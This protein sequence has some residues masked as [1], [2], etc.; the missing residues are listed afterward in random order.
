MAKVSN[1]TTRALLGLLVG[2]ASVCS[3]GG[4][5]EPIR[6]DTAQWAW[7]GAPAII[8][9]PGA[10]A[11]INAFS[12][13][14][15]V[16]NRH[17]APQ[18]GLS[19]ALDFQPNGD[20]IE[21]DA[22]TAVAFSH[23]GQYVIVAAAGKSP[24]AAMLSVYSATDLSPVR[25]IPLTHA[26]ELFALMATQPR[27]VLVNPGSNSI[28]VVDYEA[29]V[30]L[31]V[32]PVGDLPRAVSISPDDTTAVVQGSLR[33]FTDLS[34]VPWSII[35]LATNTETA[36]FEST[37]QMG[38]MTALS[39]Y[40]YGSVLDGPVF[41]TAGDQVATLLLEWPD[42]GVSVVDLATQDTTHVPV[43]SEIAAFGRM[44]A[45]PDGSTV[46]IGYQTATLDVRVAVIDTATWAIQDF[47]ITEESFPVSSV[48]LL[49]HPDGNRIVVSDTVSALFI[50]DVASGT[51]EPVDTAG[52]D[53]NAAWL[54]VANLGGGTNFLVWIFGATDLGY[55][56]FDWDGN[57]SAELATP[58]LLYGSD[59]FTQMI[60][61]SPTDPFHIVL[62]DPVA[63]A[64]DLALVDLTPANPQVL[65]HTQAGDGGIEG[66]AAAKVSVSADEN[67]A[68]VLNPQSSS[69]FFLDLK[70]NARQWVAT[71]KYVSDA[72][73][74]PAGDAALLVAGAS[75]TGPLIDGAARLTR[76]ERSG[77]SATDI[78]LPD[79]AYG[80]TLALDAAGDYAYVLLGY[81]DQP[82]SELARI[83]LATG[84]LDA[85]R[86]PVPL[87]LTYLPYF[88][89]FNSDV[90]MLSITLNDS[91]RWF[92][93]SHAGDVL[94][95]ASGSPDGNTQ[96]TLVDKASWSVL[97]S[98]ALGPVRAQAQILEFSPDDS[99]LYVGTEAAMSV[100]SLDG[101]DS[102]LAQQRAL[103]LTLTDFALSPDGTK[104]YLGTWPSFGGGSD[105]VQ[106]WS[107]LGT[108]ETITSFPLPI[109]NDF[110]FPP[111][112]WDQLNMPT[113]LVR[114]SDDSRLYA[115][116]LND[117]VHAIDVASDQVVA[118]VATGFL[119]P[120]SIVRLAASDTGSDRFLM[121]SFN[122][123]NDG[124][125][126]L[127]LTQ[128]AD[129]I[130]QN[131]FD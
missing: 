84:Q 116:S 65:V 57:W 93:Q 42:I 14:A 79:G 95:V 44:V 12:A 55:E 104:L 50:L 87:T 56:I 99:R 72:L 23:D 109:V 86:L 81:A 21:V 15:F 61:T 110:G 24:G 47:F 119:S 125:A 77:G 36:R 88:T 43:A 90:L 8:P 82:D 6:L 71:P 94:A 100:I 1:R 123:A 129:S 10:H 27:A 54:P 91:R 30:E 16:E 97:T 41:R 128:T 62:L 105:M 51:A 89:G 117:E 52:I 59:V 92:A 115:F 78:P 112:L 126:L 124:V 83:D 63:V 49:M 114:S 2:T 66:D 102:E 29:G 101:V 106:V 108:L 45:T 64:E 5:A 127:T 74:T 120:T 4:A 67:I 60:A 35:D 73:L 98:I 68:L 70:T 28:S 130:F 17:P 122:N 25:T 48:D 111:S 69:A 113:R 19:F 40:G 31:A 46:A 9:S 20:A 118:S 53:Y 38:G 13:P 7:N 22:P 58:D 37:L 96:I 33:A 11:G 39:A 76:V 32:I 121:T 26:P 107:A 85:T 103:D 34:D 75:W 18:G 80:R 3:A 131:G